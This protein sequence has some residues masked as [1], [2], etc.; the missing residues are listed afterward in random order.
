MPFL[1]THFSHHREAF[2]TRRALSLL[3]RRRLPVLGYLILA[4]ATGYTFQVER[5]HSDQN[6]HDLAVQ[7]RTVLVKGCERQNV[8]RV[9]LR[10]LILQGIPQTKKFLKEG[11]LTQ[12][13]AHRTIKITRDAAKKLAPTNCTKAYPLPER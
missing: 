1:Q 2:G 3:I 5:D 8:L 6:R 4:I 10:H 7:T 11:T 12:A 9:T 13:Q